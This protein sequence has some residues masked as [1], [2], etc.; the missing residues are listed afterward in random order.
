VIALVAGCQDD[1]SRSWHGQIHPDATTRPETGADDAAGN[2]IGFYY[3]EQEFTRPLSRT[4]A[5]EILLNTGEFAEECV[6][7]AGERSIQVEAWQVL[8]RQPD[9]ADVFEDLA[10]RGKP[11]G[12]LYGL[13]GLYLTDRHRYA[14]AE[15]TAMTSTASVY[16]HWGC[17]GATR[18]VRDLIRSS[19]PNVIEPRPGETRVQLFQRMIDTKSDRDI[20]RGGIPIALRDAS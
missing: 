15:K 16:E 19:S 9:A 18:P 3:A 6:G 7:Y 11:A 10:R 20:S 2:P 14:E 4:A 8:L 1:L 17:T 12:Q 5:F 13:C